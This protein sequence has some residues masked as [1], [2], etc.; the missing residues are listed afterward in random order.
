MR[1][2]TTRNERMRLRVALEMDCMTPVHWSRALRVLTEY[3]TMDIFINE[4]AD[5]T[6]ERVAKMDD[7]VALLMTFV[8]HARSLIGKE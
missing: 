1:N 5:L 4:I 3:E 7:P 8:R 6:I 2:T